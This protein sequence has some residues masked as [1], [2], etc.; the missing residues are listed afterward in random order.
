MATG[1]SVRFY[2]LPAWRALRRAALER[3][4][5]LCVVS[6]CGRR[7]THVDHIERRPHVATPSAADRLD[8]LRSLCAFHDAQVKERPSG[9]RQRGGR[10]SIRGADRDGWP[11]DPQRRR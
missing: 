1:G 10:F 9:T 6:G 4:G 11:M 5:F 2:A 7:A 8:N 3:D